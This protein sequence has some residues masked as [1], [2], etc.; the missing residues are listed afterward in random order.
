MQFVFLIN[1][2]VLLALAVLMAIVALIFPQTSEIFWVGFMLTGLVGALVSISN[3]RPDLK[4]RAPHSFLLTTT[5]WMTAAIAG[6]LPLMLWGMSPADA[7]FEAMSGITTTGST[8][9]SGLDTTPPGILI[10]R[11]ILQ[12]LGGI[13]FI[14]AGVALLPIMKV[15]GMQLFRTESSEKGE[16][17]LANAAHF[18]LATLGAYAALMVLCGILYMAGGM[19]PFDAVTHAMTTLSTG[20]YSNYDASFGHFTSPFLQYTATLFMLLAALPFAWYIR[21][22]MKG[23]FANEQVRTLVLFVLGAAIVLT[24]WLM[25]TSDKPLE[26]AFRQSI[27][28]IVAAVTTTGY[29]TTDYTL[30]GPFAVAFFFTITAVGGCTGSTSGG[31]KMMRWIVFFRLAGMQLR[32]IAMPHAVVVARY[33]GRRIEED[34]VSGVVNFFMLYFGVIAFL[35]LALS[36]D[37]LDFETAIS[38][39]MTAVANVGPGVG[40]IIGPAGNFSSL[41]DPAKILLSLGMFMGRLELLTV[42]VLLSPVYWRSV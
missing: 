3:A 32:R 28:N 39:A 20:G 14:V 4:I 37:G 42:F 35:A 8:V 31:A 11:A 2:F 17:E 34:V 26:E 6:A 25:A 22:M 24:V 18:A 15:G 5:I 13:G 41:D 21:V 40:S 33:E 36:L 12:A 16:K 10:W 27:F 38:G 19:S 7:F 9:M 30:W 23:S 29:A 1:G